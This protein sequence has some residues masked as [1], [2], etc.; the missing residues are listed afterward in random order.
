[1]PDRNAL[2]A[3][4]ELSILNVF[5][6]DSCQLKYMIAL[7][8]GKFLGMTARRSR[9]HA[10]FFAPPSPASTLAVSAKLIGFPGATDR[11]CWYVLAIQ[12]VP[13]P[14]RSVVGINQVPA[15]LL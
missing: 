7:I 5:E 9:S 6:G 10:A 13:A 4:P 3:A 11:I 12:L 14:V 1:M 2:S 8:M 15:T